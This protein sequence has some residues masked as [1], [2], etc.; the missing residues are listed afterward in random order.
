MTQHFQFP[1]VDPE[2][3]T[4]LEQLTCRPE[5]PGLWETRQRLLICISMLWDTSGWWP[6]PSSQSWQVKGGIAKTATQALSTCTFPTQEPMGD[7]GVLSYSSLGDRR[8]ALLLGRLLTIAFFLSTA[9][10]FS[11]AIL[12]L[13]ID[14]IAY[15]LT[16]PTSSAFLAKLSSTAGNREEGILFLLNVG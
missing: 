15:S 2:G 12:F 5:D 14:G 6:E 10:A 1:Y 4:M 9:C 8:D 3:D 13:S 7:D 11:Q 16:L